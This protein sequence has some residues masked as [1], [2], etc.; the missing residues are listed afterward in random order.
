MAEVRA[1]ERTGWREGCVLR[2]APELTPAIAGSHWREINLLL[3]SL[4]TLQHDLTRNGAFRP[5]LRTCGAVVAAR[6][7]LLYLASGPQRSLEIASNFGFDGPLPAG[8]QSGSRVVMATLQSRKPM[9]VS[10]SVASELEPEFRWLGDSHSL[11]IP[12]LRHGTPWGAV[13]LVRP[14]PF[15]E[16]EAVLLWLYT[17]ILEEVLAVLSG[18]GRLADPRPDQIREP[19]NVDL[20]QFGQRLDWEA[21]RSHLAD[22]PLSLVRIGWQ[23]P[24]EQA[25]DAILRAIG[26]TLRGSEVISH[27][28]DS[29]LLVCLPSTSAGEARKVVQQVRRCLVQARTY[30]DEVAVQ[31]GLR[32]ALVTYPENG[33]GGSEL[34]SALFEAYQLYQTGERESSAS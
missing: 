22:T 18:S 19:A 5:I 3:Q 17:L 10:S 23:P 33:R 11:T 14:V 26:C 9:L 24:L 34:M 21:K 27:L 31:N 6:R 4:A 12:I 16:E 1:L 2:H 8:L 13:Q 25:S 32:V 29:S 20:A 28:E 15:F 7:G 30:G